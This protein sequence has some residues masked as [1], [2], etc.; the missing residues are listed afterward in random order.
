MSKESQNV[1]RE[2]LR[3]PV[4]GCGYYAVMADTFDQDARAALVAHLQRKMHG[5]LLR[6]EAVTLAASVTAVWGS[7]PVTPKQQP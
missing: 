3:C 7:V 5:G 6:Q 2:H 4:E 1:L